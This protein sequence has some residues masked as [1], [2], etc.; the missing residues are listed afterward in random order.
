MPQ[1]ILLVRRL[2]LG[3]ARLAFLCSLRFI[4]ST[5]ARRSPDSMNLPPN[6][7]LICIIH[8]FNIIDLLCVRIP[9]TYS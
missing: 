9:L 7:N 5:R 6:M 2:D 1:V 8:I 3:Y 4:V